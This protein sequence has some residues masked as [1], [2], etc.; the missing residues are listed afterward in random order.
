MWVVQRQRGGRRWWLEVLAVVVVVS[1]TAAAAGARVIVVV[2]AAAAEAV[3]L[4]LLLLVKGGG[5]D[6]VD[7]EAGATGLG[8]GGGGG[9]AGGH[10]DAEADAGRR[11]WLLLL[12][13][14]GVVLLQ[15][16]ML[17][18]RVVRRMVLRVLYVLQVLQVL[19]G[20]V[21]QVMVQR[22]GSR[23]RRLSVRLGQ[24][25]HR[26]L[27]VLPGHPQADACQLSSAL[28]GA[29]ALHK[30]NSNS[31][32]DVGWSFSFGFFFFLSSLKFKVCCV[33]FSFSCSLRFSNCSVFTL[34]C[35][36]FFDFPMKFFGLKISSIFNSTFRIFKTL[37]QVSKELSTFKKYSPQL[38]HRRRAR[39]GC[40]NET[41]RL[42]CMKRTCRRFSAGA[43]ASDSALA[44]LFATLLL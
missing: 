1:G 33:W 18:R 37:G 8:G 2:V 35:K 20:V 23:R 42:L 19:Q 24:Y 29:S 26:V 32:T 28:F 16:V 17:Q 7:H 10:A 5:Q 25:A 15:E 12:L 31:V 34:S 22:M 39:L 6:V 41:E 14:C 38:S 3:L 43:A 40:Q 36:V 27:H 21:V 44:A 4:L 13:L 30:K 9:A 11:R